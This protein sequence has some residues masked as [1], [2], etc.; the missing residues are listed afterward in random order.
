MSVSAM[1]AVGMCARLWCWTS[2][3]C[4]KRRCGVADW[5]K[6]NPH[7]SRSKPYGTHDNVSMRLYRTLSVL[8]ERLS[9]ESLLLKEKTDR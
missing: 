9:D 6:P 5:P 7:V 2:Y 8:V 1:R 3:Q 4:S